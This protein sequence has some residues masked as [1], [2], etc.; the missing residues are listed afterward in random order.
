MTMKRK[1][2]LRV[3]QTLTAGLTVLGTIDGGAADP[4]YIVWNHTAWCPMACKFFSSAERAKHEAGVLETLAHPNIVRSLGLLPPCCLLMPFLSGPTLATLI[5]TSPKRFS[6]DN[7]I[8]IA[9]HIGSALLYLHDQGLLHM[10]VKPDNII[11]TPGGHPVLF[12]L[13]TARRREAS[14]PVRC[15]GTNLYIAPEE[16]ELREVGT[17]ADVFSF[18]VTIYE[19][20]TGELPFGLGTKSKPFPQLKGH[21]APFSDHRKGLC[22]QF[23]NLVFACLERNP[24]FRPELR[25][26]LVQLNGMIRSGARMWPAGFNPGRHL[27]QA[28]TSV[29]RT[30]RPQDDTEVEPAVFLVLAPEQVLSGSL[31]ITEPVPEIWTG[32]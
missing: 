10:D 30:R 25:D 21:P 13:G 6:A 11:V 4:V 22:P 23:E 20:L 15:I 1:H 18:G 24:G 19:I 9:L 14:R 26:I 28:K 31:A 2:V 27:H 16:C 8:R 29:K 17:A 5:D 3:G 12:D 32:C 7:A